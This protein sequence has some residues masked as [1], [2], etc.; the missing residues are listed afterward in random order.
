MV[1]LLKIA[2]RSVHSLSKQPKGVLQTSELKQKLPCYSHT[3]IV[4]VGGGHACLHLHMEFPLS[5]A[6]VM[7]QSILLPF[8]CSQTVKITQQHKLAFHSTGTN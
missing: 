2:K 5:M 3:S 6:C 1:H 8:E 7:I 4:C